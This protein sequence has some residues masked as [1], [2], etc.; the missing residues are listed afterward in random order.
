MRA[1]CEA[2]H[3]DIRPLSHPCWV[4]ALPTSLPGQRQSAPER[5]TAGSISRVITLHPPP[6]VSKGSRGAARA[7]EVHGWLQLPC[8]HP[9][10]VTHRAKEQP[11]SRQ[12][13]RGART[14]PAPV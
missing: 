14:A 5:C 9:P 11:Q 8:D 6:I 13:P 1:S 12:G 10:P 4:H 3:G 2:F 7:R